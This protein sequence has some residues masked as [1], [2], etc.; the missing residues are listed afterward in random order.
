[1]HA[2]ALQ[3]ASPPSYPIAGNGVHITLTTN[4]PVYH[5]LPHP[6]LR[7]L[8]AAVMRV[9]TAEMSEPQ[10]DEEWDYPEEVDLQS[11]IQEQLP[12]GDPQSFSRSTPG[13]GK[14]MWPNRPPPTTILNG[15]VHPHC[16]DL[17]PGPEVGGD[18]PM[19][20]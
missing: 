16:L 15:N 9:W 11:T 4:N 19:V 20:D 8:Q 1:M 18:A 6:D 13:K 2:T 5:P 12:P 3:E 7:V 10:D 17:L 14:V